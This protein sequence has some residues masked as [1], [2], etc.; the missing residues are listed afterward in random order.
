[1][2]APERQARADAADALC[3]AAFARALAL[4]RPTDVE[5]HTGVALVAV[6][7]VAAAAALHVWR[8]LP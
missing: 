5:D 7:G 6:G 2:T 4:E 3:S 1:M 8:S